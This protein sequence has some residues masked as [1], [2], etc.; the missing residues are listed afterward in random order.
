MLWASKQTGFLFVAS[1]VDLLFARILQLWKLYCSVQKIELNL[2]RIISDFESKT[3][4]INSV[5]SKVYPFLFLVSGIDESNLLINKASISEYHLDHDFSYL[6]HWSDQLRTFHRTELHSKHWKKLVILYNL[7]DSCYTLTCKLEWWLTY[8]GNE[9]LKLSLGDETKKYNP[10]KVKWL[11]WWNCKKDFN[12]VC[13]S[14]M[15]S[16]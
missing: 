2:L 14:M 8:H 16:P 10:W 3:T 6:L 5:K 13:T 11:S 7:H 9:V 4:T 1:D 15:R 12:F